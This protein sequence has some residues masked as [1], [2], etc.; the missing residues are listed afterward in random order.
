[1]RGFWRLELQ[2]VL[3]RKKKK[4]CVWVCN[5]IQMVSNYGI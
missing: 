1:M 4:L 5:S 2:L 3:T